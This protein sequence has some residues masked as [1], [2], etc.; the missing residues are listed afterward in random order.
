MLK[1]FDDNDTSLF[2]HT[3]MASMMDWNG[4]ES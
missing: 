4:F 2:V 3:G 1:L